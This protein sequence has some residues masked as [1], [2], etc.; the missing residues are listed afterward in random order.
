MLQQAKRSDRHCFE[1]GHVE[2]VV[3][4]NSCMEVFLLKKS[5][6]TSKY[7]FAADG[8][9]YIHFLCS[10]PYSIVLS[11]IVHS[12]FPASVELAAMTCVKR[13]AETTCNFSEICTSLISIVNY[14]YTNSCVI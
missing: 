13:H 1:A 6:S 3:G 2:L 8:D 7:E 11:G 14:V 5:K 10:D 4:V 12:L 9:L